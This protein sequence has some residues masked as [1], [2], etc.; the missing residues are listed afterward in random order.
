MESVNKPIG[1]LV[2]QVDILLTNGIDNI[3]QA[4][5]LT[6]TGWQVIHTIS[7]TGSIDNS[8]LSAVMQ[9]FINEEQMQSLLQ[10]LISAG[11]ICP[12]SNNTFLLT[13]K[14]TQLHRECFEAQKIFRKKLVKN[15][16]EQEY[17][18]TIQTLQKMIANL[19]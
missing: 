12:P 19:L 5:G 1:H 16:T 17:A 10:Q 4:F 3:Q 13:E 7:I 6:R 9:P 14:G 15:V 11:V 18:T 8:G 2:K